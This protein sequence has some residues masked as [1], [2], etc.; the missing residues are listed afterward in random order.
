M[1][2]VGD[3]KKTFLDYCQL[4]NIALCLRTHSEHVL[5]TFL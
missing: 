1:K 3:T 5:Q 2:V 4:E